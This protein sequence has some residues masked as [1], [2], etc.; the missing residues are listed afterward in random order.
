MKTN[1]KTHSDDMTT[2]VNGMDDSF[3][4]QLKSFGEGYIMASNYG[5]D[6][7]VRSDNLSGFPLDNDGVLWWPELGVRMNK[8]VLRGVYALNNSPIKAP[9]VECDFDDLPG[10]LSF[11]FLP[12]HCDRALFWNVMNA[13]HVGVIPVKQLTAQ[14][15]KQM[16]QFNTCPCCVARAERI[17]DAVELHPISQMLV[18]LSTLEK[19]VEFNINT[20]HVGMTAQWIPLEVAHTAGQISVTGKDHT[21]RINAMMVHA[22]RIFKRTKAKQNYSV[23]RCYSSL[24][25]VMLEFSVA[26]ADHESLWNKMC[27]SDVS[28][29][30][31]MPNGAYLGG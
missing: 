5:V 1:N 18:N 22:I 19:E 14:R 4:E 20:K 30:S 10:G 2:C 16:S 13:Y 28:N 8:N 25:D 24:G 21:L 17:R 11:Y 29:Y 27:R 3:Y 31:P 9:A 23:M 15:C 6:M 26:G 7:A 12:E